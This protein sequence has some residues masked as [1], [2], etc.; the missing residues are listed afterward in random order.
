[1]LTAEQRATLDAAVLS[2]DISKSVEEASSWLSGSSPPVPG[3]NG[4][5]KAAKKKP[6]ACACACACRACRVRVSASGLRLPREVCV[7]RGADSPSVLPAASCRSGAVL[8]VR[9]R[10]HQGARLFAEQGR[11]EL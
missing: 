6:S 8:G 10:Q 7:V 2:G 5:P 11:P 4:K 1:M 9:V 3:R